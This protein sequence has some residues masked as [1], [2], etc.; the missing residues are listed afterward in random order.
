MEELLATMALKSASPDFVLCVENVCSN[1][2]IYN[3]RGG[4]NAKPPK[5]VLVNLVDM[6]VTRFQ[7][8]EKVSLEALKVRRI[9][10]PL[11]SEEKLPFEGAR[12]WGV[13]AILVVAKEK[14]N[15]LGC[16]YEILPSF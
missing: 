4:M 7:E 3:I 8:G 5:Y 13:G 1:E 6:F 2:D 12:R 15:N 14:L 10:N 11:G 9:I 16:K